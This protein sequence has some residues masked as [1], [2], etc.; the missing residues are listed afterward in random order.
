MTR[1]EYEVFESVRSM[2]IDESI[3]DEEEAKSM[4]YQEMVVGFHISQDGMP[5]ENDDVPAFLYWLGKRYIISP[6]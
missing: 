3:F 5:S 2:V 4:G 1:Y 6:E